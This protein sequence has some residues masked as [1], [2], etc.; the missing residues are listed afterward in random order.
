MKNALLFL[1]MT[2]ASGCAAQEIAGTVYDF[3]KEPVINGTI[4]VYKEGVLKSATTTDYDGHYVIKPLPSGYYDVLSIYPGYDSAKYTMVN[5][6]PGTQTR[7]NFDLALAMVKP[8]CV[9][10]VYAK[11][12]GEQSDRHGFVDGSI[13]QLPSTTVTDAAPIN[14]ILWS[15][16]H[17]CGG[18]SIG[19][20]RRD[21]TR[22]YIVDGV[23]IP[24]TRL[25]DVA[26]IVPTPV[27]PTMAGDYIFTKEIIDNM[28]VNAI[29]D[30]PSLLPGVYQARRGDGLNIYGARDNGNRYIIDGVWQ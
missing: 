4:L 8:K 24:I 14:C 28:P 2:A 19:G 17:S 22:Y 16:G 12:F 3:R 11:H 23:I 27:Y 25:T 20:S 29:N 21:T 15:Q 30:I 6:I 13:N 26:T 1:M 5:V 9:S 10:V 7:L 18:I